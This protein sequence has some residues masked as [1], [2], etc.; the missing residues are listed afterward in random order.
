MKCLA[1]GTVCFLSFS[2][3]FGCEGCGSG[4]PT[5]GDAVTDTPT[6]VLVCTDRDGDGYGTG[7]SQGGD[8]DDFDPEH[9]SD[10]DDC[11]STHAEGCACE[12]GDSFFCYEGPAGTENVGQCQR[13]V[14]RCIDGQLGPC[15]GQVLPDRM[16]DCEDGID[17]NCNGEVDE[18]Y[19]CGDCTPP[20]HTEGPVE[21]SP[22]DPGASGLIPNPDGPGVILGS[23]EDEGGFAWIANTDDGTVSKLDIFTGA[24]LGRYRV[25]LTGTGAD[26]PSRTAVD[27]YQSAYVANR[28]FDRQGS[29]TKIAGF[30]RYCIDRNGNGTI[31]TSHGSE[32]LALGEDECV[33]WTAEVGGV[34]GIPRALV[35]DYGT[36]D[37]RLGFP[38]VGL[39][40]EMRFYKLSPAD[41]SVLETVDVD[42]HTYGAAIDSEGWIW[43]SGRSSNAIQRFHYLSYAVEPSIP[44]PASPCGGTDPYGITVDMNDR[45]WVGVWSEGGACRYDPDD[46]SWFFVG[47]GGRGRGVAVD[48]DN[49]IWVSNDDNNT[50][51]RFNADD[52]G[53]LQSY[54]GLGTTPIG[55]GA[56][57]LGKIWTINHGSN[58]ASRFN[59]DTTTFESFPVGTHPYTYSDFLGFQRWLHMPVG[60][61]IRSFERCDLREGDAWLHITW[62]TETPSDSH[63]TILGR[64]ADTTG[65]ILSAPEVTIAEIGP[66]PDSGSRDLETVYTA[67]GETLGRYLE[68]T[69]IMVPASVELLSPVFK[70]LQ[71]FFTCSELG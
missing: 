39:F 8:C 9:W 53:G 55:V 68:I 42:V 65:E 36:L 71:V 33:L 44:V 7:C 49:V 58:N 21:P 25:G 23:S 15:E 69:V 35:I 60:I 26:A 3:L 31:D 30:E 70:S 22:S 51:Y 19:L 43:I 59:P 5:Y 48:A 34:N 17:N 66:D 12:A 54:G 41:G 20:C 63:I 56:D 10:C 11:A 24:E 16:E 47:T 62:D 18:A 46:G 64:S 40:N 2:G 61:W 38:W 37:T 50:L 57:R 52:G 14:R 29:V 13:G 27:D 45:V 32:P 1:I 28:A 6:E 67:A 4:S